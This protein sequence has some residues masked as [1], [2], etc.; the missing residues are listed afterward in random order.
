MDKKPRHLDNPRMKKILEVS[1]KILSAHRQQLAEES[2]E[3]QDGNTRTAMP[4]EEKHNN[5]RVNI[6]VE[7]RGNVDSNKS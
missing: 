5:Y 1:D 4:Q 6:G 7:V 2:I 3:C